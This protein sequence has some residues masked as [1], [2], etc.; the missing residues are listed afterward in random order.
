MTGLGVWVRGYGSVVIRYIQGRLF[1]FGLGILKLEV[2]AELR[3]VR[4]E[5]ETSSHNALSPERET[6][7]SQCPHFL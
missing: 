4:T 7:S 2:S 1:A 3:G 5:R 6:F